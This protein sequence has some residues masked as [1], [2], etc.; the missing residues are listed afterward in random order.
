MAEKKLPKG[1]RFV[2][3]SY[4]AR[5]MINGKTI[6]MR[7][8]DLDQ[9][10]EEFEKAKQEVRSG[11]EYMTG[12]T[13]LDEWFDKWFDT[14][15]AKKVKETSI[16]P[17]KNSYKRNFGFYIGKKKLK[18]IR[19]IDIQGVINALGKEGRIN[20]NTRDALGRLSKCFQFAVAN[21]LI[22]QNPCLI[23]EVPWEFKAV[24]EE[25]ALTQDE[26]NRF[27][28]AV[29]TSWYKELFYFMFL[30]GVRVGE[31][32]GL[33]WRDIDW[34]REVVTIRHSLHCQYC[35]GEKTMML[36]SPKTVNSV[37]E[38]PFIGEMKEILKAQK[39]KQAKQR[40]AYGSRWRSSDDMDDLVFTTTVGSPCVRYIV[41]KE[42]KKTLKRMDEEDMMVA[43]A[44]GRDPVKFRYFHP[45]TIRH[46]F[47]TRCF[48]NG[49]E[50]KVAQKLLG[51][52]SISITLNIY[53]H[54]M[55]S[56]MDDEISK[57]GNARTNADEIPEVYRGVLDELKPIS[58]HSHL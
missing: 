24:K 23:V 45:H 48:E 17:M 21:Q 56:K 18:D 1:I 15:Q 39:K 47:A 44:E 53:T 51:H 26:Q 31:V 49:I 27:L 54:V 52:S 32:G 57:F 12:S 16:A 9:L 46:T 29:E 34:N 5:A 35:N 38:I 10:I 2:K 14:V 58:I 20:T 36:T 40:K 8:K 30:T 42:I 41:D 55:E 3:G 37:R 6:S 28:E 11:I 7:N 19:P 13:T 43:A 4:E 25:I 33:R 22:K 50:P